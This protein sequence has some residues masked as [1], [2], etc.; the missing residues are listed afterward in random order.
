MG[1]LKKAFTKKNQS[2]EILRFQIKLK[3]QRDN[4]SHR[5]I[6]RMILRAVV[7]NDRLI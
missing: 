2:Y 6:M 4:E 3:T 7:L 1:T 5:L